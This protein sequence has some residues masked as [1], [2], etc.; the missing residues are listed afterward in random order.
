MVDTKEKRTK[1]YPQDVLPAARKRSKI[2][3]DPLRKAIE[4]RTAMMY[5]VQK[6]QERR[7]GRG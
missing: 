6:H 1:D 2:A 5:N 4:K 7:W 3:T